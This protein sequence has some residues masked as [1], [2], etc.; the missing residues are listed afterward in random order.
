MPE[1]PEI[2]T[3]RLQLTD[4]IVG[5]KIKSIEIL[6]KKCFFGEPSFILGRKIKGLR[7][8]AKMLVIDLE[9][10][11]Y[12]IVHLKMSGQLIIRSKS[13]ESRIKN[14][15]IIITDPILKNLPNKHTRV[16]MS[17][18]SGDKLYFNDMRMFG[19]MKIVGGQ[20]LKN[21][22]KN[23]GPEPFKDLTM[24]KF[25]RILA[26]SKK[27]I[28]L[29]LMDQTKIAGVGNI[30]ANDSLFLSGIHPKTGA[31]TI[32][33]KRIEKLYNSLL[34]V[35]KEGIKYGGAS[36]N[37]FRNAY[38]GK[39]EAQYHFRVYSKEGEMCPGRC[40]GRIK[41]IKLGGRGTFYCAICQN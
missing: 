29:L 30:Y 33:N 12:V 26:A 5:Q 3:L 32:E 10:N 41:K 15:K 35:L 4:L 37:N 11:L 36:R 2:E 1:L 14:R 20:T 39:G 6:R 13:I 25:K 9:G 28:K 22:I 21:L 24:E 27:P 8:F 7:R 34:L 23:Y 31:S 38:G 16:I 40:G 17:F 19:W 18:V